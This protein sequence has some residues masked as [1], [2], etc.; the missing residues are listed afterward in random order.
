MEVELV[1]ICK[2]IYTKKALGFCS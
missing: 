2:V 1:S